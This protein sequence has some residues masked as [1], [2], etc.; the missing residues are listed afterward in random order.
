MHTDVEPTKTTFTM[1]K[2]L[3]STLL[4]AAD[5]GYDHSLKSFFERPLIIKRGSWNTSHASTTLLNFF[6][7]PDSFLQLPLITSKVR[8]FLGFK[9]T[10]IVK[11]Q[12]NTNRFQMGR[13]VMN[14]FPQG[15]S[16]T[17][18]RN[19]SDKHLMYITQLPRIDFD[20]ATDSEVTFE[21]P[22]I[23]T[24]LM[25]NV[26]S[27]QGNSGQVQLFV[28]EPLAVVSGELT[29]DYTI[30]LSFKDVE[31]TFPTIPSGFVAQSGIVSRRKKKASNPSNVEQDTEREGPISS[32]LSASSKFVSSFQN[33]PILSSYAGPTS[34]FLSCASK[35]ASAF[36][37]SNPLN[38]RP[39]IVTVQQSMSR[40]IN[41]SG[42]DNSINL[43]LNEDNS[44]AHLPGFAGSDV[45]EL[46]MQHVLSIP[47]FFFRQ[48]WN[49][50][51]SAGDQL[52]AF[53][54]CP[55]YFILNAGVNFPIV[56]GTP[57]TVYNP[58]PVGY[59]GKLFKYYRGSIKITMKIV[60][61]EFHTGRLLI[62][63]SPSF[64][65]DPTH[66][67][68]D[69][70][71][72]HREVVDLRYSNEITI[73]CPY[74][75]TRPWLPISQPYG[76]FYVNVLN[77]LRHP[78]TVPVAVALLFE[79]SCA[80]DFEFSVPIPCQFAPV[81]YLQTTLPPP[82]LVSE[83]SYSKTKQ[84]G[85]LDLDVS[86]FVAQAG[87]DVPRQE[88]Q[89][90]QL[91]LQGGPIGSSQINHDAGASALYCSGEK[92]LSLRQI[93]KRANNFSKGVASPILTINPHVIVLPNTVSLYGTNWCPDN[94][95]YINLCYAFYRGSIRV[96][97]YGY[98]FSQGHLRVGLNPNLG[99]DIVSVP[100]NTIP[101]YVSG[102]GSDIDNHGNW[103]WVLNAQSTY[104]FVEIQVPFY[105][106]T[107]CAAVQTASS[108]PPYPIDTQIDG[109]APHNLL[110]IFS[111]TSTTTCRFTRQAG[112]DWSSG[113]F[114]GTSPIIAI[115]NANYPGISRL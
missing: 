90:V 73:V 84:E 30:W 76:N 55:D 70:N 103:P 78:D 46:S 102:V 65:T 45:D 101:S 21:I 89:P 6:R 36:G 40:S 110:T 88:T 32:I 75:S 20:A 79:I 37:F 11:L 106:A 16:L 60:K 17:V 99:S 104:P 114:L 3:P 112:D 69:M 8:G 5:D 96:R 39:Q 34:W 28:Y 97:I 48:S 108:F 92:I 44:I 10:A 47:T 87:D 68:D 56:G 62:G 83:E 49:D 33:V 27:G 61:T 95:A 52:V 13:L 105:S 58:T 81:T 12:V 31:L 93:L 38:V 22:F 109:N 14:Y 66:T 43:G 51:S 4:S 24:D 77:D 107:H 74:A 35:A 42:L 98:D 86:T 67:N 57:T 29:A 80:E 25:F 1:P 7:I 91:T 115:T 63:Y 50:L 85:T 94:F 19:I 23:N 53:S 64:G 41:D 82:G 71:Y 54:L 59:F 18:K 2:L 15:D 72:I 100:S 111:S 9:G 113:F 26:R